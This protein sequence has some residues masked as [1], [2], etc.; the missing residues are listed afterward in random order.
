VKPGEGWAPRT[1]EQ[2][3][4]AYEK[5]KAEAIALAE[6]HLGAIAYIEGHLFEPVTVKSIAANSGFSPSRFSRGFTRLQ[7]ESVMA[8]VRGRR[9][10]EA[11]RRLRADPGV[12][13][14]DLA[15]DCGFDSQ[16]AFTRAFV[17]AFDQP[18]GRLK[19]RGAPYPLV[20]RRK[21]SQEKPEIQE[22]VEQL[23]EMHFAGL[24]KHF[25]PANYRE[26][27]H[28]WQGIVAAKGF[29]GQLGDESYGVRKR[30]PVDGSFDF[31]AAVRIDPGCRPPEPLQV[32][33]LPAHTYL[34]FRHVLHAG[35]LYPQVNAAAD[36]IWSERLGRSGRVLSDTAE[37]QL[38]PAPFRINGGWIDN[39]LPVEG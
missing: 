27:G 18:P 7:G 19:G 30:Y 23:P 25:T 11:M 38:Y 4:A 32:L 33:T 36:V 17:R 2:E 10:E 31:M 3:A 16:E 39:Y 15:F 1:G 8:Y 9:L 29:R 12:R 6:A 26:M 13:I 37:F 28:L 14:V 35:D 24:R 5:T 34:V 22:R 21:T 20:R